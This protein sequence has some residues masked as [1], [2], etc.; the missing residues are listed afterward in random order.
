MTASRTRYL[1]FL[2]LF[3]L[4]GI[5]GLIAGAYVG[6]KYGMGS[7]IDNVMDR[8]ARDVR[9]LVGALRDLQDGDHQQAIDTIQGLVNDHLIVLDE[10]PPYPGI[11]ERTRARVQ[12]AF[13]DYAAYRSDYPRA[14]P[15]P[16]DPMVESS[17]EH[18]GLE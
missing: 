5:S 7:V 4:G 9:S 18:R 10:D 17:L 16:T 15:L 14:V 1:V 12:D 11:E 8:D 2:L 6:G 13:E 3:L